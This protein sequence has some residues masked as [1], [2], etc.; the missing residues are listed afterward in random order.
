MGRKKNK[1]KN[2]MTTLVTSVPASIALVL[3]EHPVIAGVFAGFM[4]YR[5]CKGL[6]ARR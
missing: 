2:A 4:V 1:M 6:N 3:A 5:Y